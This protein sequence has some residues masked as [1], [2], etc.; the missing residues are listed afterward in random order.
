MPIYSFEP[1]ADPMS[2]VLILGTMPGKTSLR[3]KQYYA[4]PRNLFWAVTGA[5]LG[6]EPREPYRSRLKA[7]LSAGVALWDVLKTCERK[8]SLD[9]DIVVPTEVPNDLGAFLEAHPRITRICFNGARAEV[10]FSRHVKH[11]IS[12]RIKPHCI[13]LPSTS[14]AN[15]SIPLEKKLAAWRAIRPDETP[16]R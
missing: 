15:A 1:V 11:L 2:R 10:L 4:H 13:R 14:P 8:S 7:L 16:R 3:E 12:N 9:S 6:F 5:A